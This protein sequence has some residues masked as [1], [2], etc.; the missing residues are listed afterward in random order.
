M[1]PLLGR[2][3]ALQEGLDRLVLLVELGHVRDQV[4]DDVHYMIRYGQHLGNDGSMLQ[5]ATYCEEGGIVWKPSSRF[6]RY[7]KDKP[8]C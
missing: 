7:G 3:V 1:L 2:V 6:G 5:K 8:R 4:L